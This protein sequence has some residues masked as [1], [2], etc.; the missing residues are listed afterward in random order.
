MLLTHLATLALAASA[1]AASGCGGSSK[2]AST[3]AATTPATTS[4][5]TAATTAPTSTTPA[6]TTT[7]TVATGKP[8]TRSAWIAKGDVIC[9]RLITQLSSGAPK[10]SR[11]LAHALVQSAAYERAELAQLAKLVPPSSMETD[12][13]EFLTGI[14]EI[15]TNS[16]TLGETAQSGTGT[17]NIPLLRVTQQ[18]ENHTNAVAKHDGFKHCS[19]A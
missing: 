19:R 4:V 11:E 2:S 18:I 3:S 15:A 13:Q 10:S 6:T 5:A 1:L 7:V 16:A 14:N 17:L 12:W 9:A 8:L